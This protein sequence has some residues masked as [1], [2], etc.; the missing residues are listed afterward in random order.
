MAKTVSAEYLEGIREGRA[1]FKEYGM[2]DAQGNLDTI[3]RTAL[4]FSNSSPVGQMLRGERDFWR[5]KL[6]GVK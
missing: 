4:M 6:K 3:T 2:T 5:N 1:W